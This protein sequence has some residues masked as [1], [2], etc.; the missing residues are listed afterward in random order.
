MKK[1]V[2]TMIIAAIVLSFLF[3]PLNTAT[4]AQEAEGEGYTLDN[5][6]V[7]IVF[8][9]LSLKHG[10][11]VRSFSVTFDKSFYNELAEEG[12]LGRQELMGF[13]S[14]YI[15]AIGFESEIDLQGKIQGI[16][17]YDS[18]TD[19][20]IEFGRD[21]YDKSQSDYQREESFFFTETTMTQTTIF[22]DMLTPNGAMNMLKSALNLYG[23]DDEDISLSYHYGLPYKN[24]TTDAEKSYYDS[25]S[26]IYI[27]EFHM[28]VASSGRE[29]TVVQTSPNTQNWYMLAIVFAIPVVLAT[30]VGFAVHKLKE[31]KRRA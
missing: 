15:N 10:N 11:I 3:V 17:E 31:R 25:A 16:K 8:R 26:S 4:F 2:L 24:I 13:L 20:Y 27:H 12:T 23:I 6:L 30:L 7:E 5:A 18:P 14:N 1:F 9:N 29:I 22:E 28:S 19:M 21:G